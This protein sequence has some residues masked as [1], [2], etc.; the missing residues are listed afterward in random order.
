VCSETCLTVSAG[1]SEVSDI[2]AE[3]V[4]QTQEEGNHVAVVLPAIKAAD[5]VCY[6]CNIVLLTVVQ[7]CTVL[8]AFWKCVVWCLYIT[9]LWRWKQYA[10][11][12][13]WYPPMRL[14]TITYKVIVWNGTSW[15]SVCLLLATCDRYAAFGFSSLSVPLYPCDYL[16]INIYC[17]EANKFSPNQEIPVLSVT[18]TVFSIYSTDN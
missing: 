15:M 8:S 10:A 13:A 5:N 6:W 1:G 4:L 14:N 3:E 18:W 9:L 12:K 17:W 11:L 7:I 2:R 16:S